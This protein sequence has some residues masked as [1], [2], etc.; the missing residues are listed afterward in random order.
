MSALTKASPFEVDAIL[1][2]A[3]IDRQDAR[4]LFGFLD[5]RPDLIPT[6]I[7]LMAADDELTVDLFN[8]YFPELE[9]V[10]SC[11]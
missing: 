3:V 10:L 4:L 2:Q 6:T 7:G 1:C 5:D 8:R 9:E 11:G